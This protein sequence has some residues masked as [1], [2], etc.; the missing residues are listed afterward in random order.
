VDN[1]L[2]MLCIPKKTIQ[3]RAMVDLCERND[4]MVHDVTPMPDQDRIRED[5][6]RAQF[7]SKLDMS[8][9]Y[10]Q[11]QIV[12][13][14]VPKTAFAMINGTMLSRVI[15]QGDCNAPSTFQRLMTHIFR[16]LIGVSVHV[17]LDDI[18]IFSNTMDK[19]ETHLASVFAKLRE[20][21]M[22]LSKKK[23]D[24]YSKQMECLSHMIDDQGIYAEQDKLEQICEWRTSRNYHDVSQ[25]LGLVQYIAQFMPNVAAYTAPLLA[26]CSNGAPFQWRPI[27]DS[28]FESIKQLTCQAL[29]L[30]PIDPEATEPIWLVCDASK[31][32]VGAF[33]GQGPS[34]KTCQ[35]AGFMSK[36]LTNAQIGYATYEHEMLAILEALLRWEDQLLGR[37]IRIVTDHQTL[38]FFNTQRD[39]SY[40]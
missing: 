19:H 13:E 30:K 5:V 17:Y 7:W 20:N 27:H 36:K 3:L 29:I 34:W 31:T 21:K 6:A 24:L 9:A 33:Y 37:K 12:D 8:D 16:E 10:E 2:P 35:P 14:D 39:M 40:R 25:F 18:F 32:G 38:E 28:C 11:I 26:M 15:Q 22:F 23:V 1:A 4:N